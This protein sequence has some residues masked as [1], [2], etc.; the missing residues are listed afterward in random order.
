MCEVCE[1]D[2]ECDSLFMIFVMTLSSTIEMLR[3][4]KQLQPL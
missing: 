3:L 2:F 4:K 1:A